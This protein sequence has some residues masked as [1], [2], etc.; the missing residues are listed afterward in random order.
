MLSNYLAEL[1]GL[2][3]VAVTLAM[4]LK[5]KY[6]AM[7]FAEIENDTK[8]FCWGLATLV[9]GI[10]MILAHNLWVKDWRVVITIFGWISLIKGLT[11]LFI[12][13]QF[14]IWTNKVAMFQYIPYAL[15]VGL[16]IGLALTYFGFTA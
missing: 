4:L 8:L 1:W 5:Q 3:I 12:P 14:R 2:S 7:M 6:I 16:I 15:I 11:M 9:I 13:E 10:A